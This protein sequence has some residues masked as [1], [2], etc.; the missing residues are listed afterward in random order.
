MVEEGLDG[1]LFLTGGNNQV[2]RQYTDP[3]FF[4]VAAAENWLALLE[5]RKCRLLALRA[6]Y[7]HLLAPDKM[8]VFPKMFGRPLDSFDAHPISKLMALAGGS[9]E[10][11]IIDPT[12]VLSRTGDRFQTYF[13][14]D[15]HWTIWGAYLAYALTCKRM[16]VPDD[17]ILSFE[18]RM[19]T[20]NLQSFDLG[21]KLSTSVKEDNIF[22]PLPPHVRRVKT[23]RIVDLTEEA[24]RTGGKP[25]GMH[26]GIS[27]VYQN[28]APAAVPRRLVIFGD[29]FSGYQPSSMTALFAETFAETH[30][31]WSTNIDYDYVERAKP[32]IVLTE[33]AE[34]FMIV[35]PDDTFNLEAFVE[36]RLKFAPATD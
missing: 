32:D 35:L 30:Y 25:P 29:S 31:I 34:R 15:T 13:K 27:V 14:T 11:F 12:Q 6:D 33:V 9:S 2:L 36:G 19:F 17:Q 22:T 16:G 3:N 21:S 23:S 4:T 20:T 5:K 7:Y 18:G 26:N 8:S 24:E 1:W 10:K 28:E